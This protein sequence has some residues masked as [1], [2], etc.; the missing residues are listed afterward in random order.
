[1]MELNMFNILFNFFAN[2]TRLVTDFKF[3]RSG[4]VKFEFQAPG[5]EHF[6]V[7]I[8]KRTWSQMSGNY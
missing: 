7:K 1:M 3:I 2:V 8:S 6:S 5:L 4:P